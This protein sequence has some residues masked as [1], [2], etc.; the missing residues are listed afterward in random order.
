MSA[1]KER[2]ERRRLEVTRL[3]EDPSV[4]KLGDACVDLGG[5]Y[6]VRAEDDR[7]PVDDGLSV[8]G[9]VAQGEHH[10]SGGVEKVDAIAAVV[11]H[12]QAV[13]DLVD[14]EALDSARLLTRKTITAPGHLG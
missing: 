13:L 10:G 8:S 9:P 12:D 6:G 14:L 1:Y 4:L 3:P 5:G 11:V 2:D 7:H